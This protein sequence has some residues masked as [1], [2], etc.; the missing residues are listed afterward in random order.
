MLLG[1]E[2]VDDTDV[3]EVVL[4][5]VETVVELVGVDTGVD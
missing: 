5:G 3:D 4:L 1:V 2:P